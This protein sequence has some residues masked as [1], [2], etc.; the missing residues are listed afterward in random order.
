[1][2]DSFE[3]KSYYSYIYTIQNMEGI[4]SDTDYFNEMQYI[5]A[6]L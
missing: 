3:Y 1:M 6:I 2:N 4:V 5:L